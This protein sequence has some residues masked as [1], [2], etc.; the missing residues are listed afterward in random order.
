MCRTYLNVDAF[1]LVFVIRNTGAN[2]DYI[3]G[4]LE[5]FGR[6]QDLNFDVVSEAKQAVIWPGGCASL[7]GTPMERSL[8]PVNTQ[9]KLE[10]GACISWGRHGQRINHRIDCL[11][12][13]ASDGAEH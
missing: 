3:R 9:L 13:P 4:S 12:R 7:M 1:A 11:P 5:S 8:F 6:T 10:A 2:G